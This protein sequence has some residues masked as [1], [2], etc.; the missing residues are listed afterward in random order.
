MRTVH[1][2]DGVVSKRVGFLFRDVSKG[3]GARCGV[4]GDVP[5]PSPLEQYIS[6]PLDALELI[7]FDNGAAAPK[8]PPFQDHRIGIGLELQAPKSLCSGESRQG[9]PSG[10]PHPRCSGG[11]CCKQ[12][13][14]RCPSRQPHDPTK[15]AD[16]RKN[17]A[18]WFFHV[19]IEDAFHHLPVLGLHGGHKNPKRG[20]GLVAGLGLSNLKRFEA[21]LPFESVALPHRHVN[22]AVRHLKGVVPDQPH[23][24]LNPL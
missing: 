1:A 2:V 23:L 22:L 14:T 6:T 3:L 15:S 20:I 9:H 21:E 4:K 17:K 10:R 11:P 18:F 19:W 24:N 8:P 7:H 16:R 5:N 12:Q 13:E